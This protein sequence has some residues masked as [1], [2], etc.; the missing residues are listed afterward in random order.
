MKGEDVRSGSADGEDMVTECRTVLTEYGKKHRDKKG[1]YQRKSH[2]K[3]S[4]HRY[5]L[6]QWP[7][8]DPQF[9]VVCCERKFRG[10]EG[11]ITH[12]RRK[13]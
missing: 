11:L 6:Y 8:K 7:L 9:F 13:H 5:C 2:E 10:A 12:L 3:L 1:C 4:W